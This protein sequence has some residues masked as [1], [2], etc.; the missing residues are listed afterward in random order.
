MDLS[1]F[2]DGIDL[3]YVINEEEKSAESYTFH[4]PNFKVSE[5]DFFLDIKDVARYRVSNG[6]T[7]RVNPYD[8]ADEDSIN[9]FI[10]GSVLGALLHQRGLLPFHG[11]S[12]SYKGKGILICGRSGAGKSSVTAAFHQQGAVFINDDISPLSVSDKETRILPVKTRIKL[13]ND[14]LGKLNI[15]ADNLNRIRPQ[16]DKFYL[17]IE[18]TP[19]LDHKLDYVFILHSHQQDNYSA[20]KLN[21]AEKF[22][23]LRQHIYRKVYLKGM[24]K[25]QKNYFQKLFLLAKEVPVISI[26]RPFIC[27]IQDTMRFIEK[28]IL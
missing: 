7:I 15:N 16:L 3:K 27:D 20:C 22:S 26:K 10:E 24:P 12:F 4:R 2:P 25:T 1:I 19:G 23:I 6:R 9:L 18:K 8:N 28:E 17:P 5:D 11:S 13:W 14:S 21:G